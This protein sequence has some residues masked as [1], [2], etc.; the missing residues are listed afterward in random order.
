[1][2]SFSQL[3]ALFTVA[4]FAFGLSGLAQQSSGA[5]AAPQPTP[6]TA[7]FPPVAGPL[8]LPAPRSFHLGPV[9]T[10]KAGGLASLMPISQTH[11]DAGDASTRLEFSNAQAFLQKPT[12]RLQFYFQIGA[13]NFPSLG[14]PLYSTAT[15]IS[16]LYG[17]VPV[18][19]LQI[20]PS[21][22]F[23]IQA[24]KLLPIWGGETTFTFQNMNVERGL[25]WNQTNA[26]NRGVQ[27]NYNHRALSASLSWNDGFYSNRWNWLSG[28]AAYAWGSKDTLS[29]TAAGNIGRTGYTTFAT[30]ALQNNSSAYDLIYTRSSGPW[31]LQP[32]FQYTRL[33]QQTAIG[34]DRTTATLGAAWLASRSMGQHWALAARGEIIHN[35]GKVGGPSTNLLYGPGSRAG[36]VT[37]TPSYARRHG[38]A[39]GEFS[40]VGVGNAGPGDAFGPFGGNKTQIR[41]T[42]EAGVM[43]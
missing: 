37:L 18:A 22:S 33:A 13:Y 5:S 39:R 30:P 23:N 41:G 16:R 25:L 14:A 11:P 38:Y 36:S 40:W 27:L 8:V 28:A 10:W 34:A 42:I 21:A 35:T 32:Y 26:I 4:M 19:Y 24:G 7:A 6:T 31:K 2:A 15:T 1:M 43:F 17:P 3:A 9:G 20:T 29:A 12:G